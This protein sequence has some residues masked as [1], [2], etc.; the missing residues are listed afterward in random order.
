M[1]LPDPDRGRR[2]A[3]LALLGCSVV[4]GL[5]LLCIFFIALPVAVGEAHLL[6]YMC[7]G[8]V[9]ALP[10]GAIYLT[11]PRLLD[12]YDPEP[13][14]VLLGCLA[15]GGITSCGVAVTLNSL[16]DEIAREAIGP[17][18]AQVVSTAVFAPIVE[19]TLKGLGILGVFYFLRREFDGLVDGF[20]YACFIALGFAAVENVVYYARAAAEGAGALTIT[21]ILRGVLAP[22]GHPV[23]TAMTGLGLGI[24]REATSR[25]LR[26]VAP[27]LGF[28]VAIMLHALWNGGAILAESLG[29]ENGIALFAILLA[30]WFVFVAVF[31]GMIISLVRRRRKILDAYLADEVVLRFVT[32]EE[33]ALVVDGSGPRR[34][35]AAFGPDGEELVRACARLATVKWHADRARVSRTQTVSDQMIMPLRQR[36]RD[37]RARIHERSRAMPRR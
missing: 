2:Q 15:W 1:N 24:A 23:Y 27:V 26:I 28:S 13:W 6:G 12:R 37:L 7:L 19:E 10:A 29:R 31:A 8:A 33:R 5:A 36:I 32:P 21:V 3:G 17:A 14:W 22:W 35:R 4:I 9:I 11:I 20:I 30:L 25:S 16:V 34:A 18:M